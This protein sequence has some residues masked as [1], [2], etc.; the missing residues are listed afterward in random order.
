LRGLADAG[1][2]DNQDFWAFF[3]ASL[4][5]A[6]MIFISVPLPWLRFSFRTALPLAKGVEFGGKPTQLR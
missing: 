1:A 4:S 6:L 2:S 3:S 5:S